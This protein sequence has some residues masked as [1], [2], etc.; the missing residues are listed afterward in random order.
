V[1]AI[2]IIVTHQLDYGFSLM[3]HI[4]SILYYAKLLSADCRLLGRV[5]AFDRHCNMVLDNVREMW[6]EVYQYMACY[7]S[8]C[9]SSISCVYVLINISVAPVTDTEDW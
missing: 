9:I 1:L 7:L 8:C 3:Y 5:R 2:S 6:T 4:L